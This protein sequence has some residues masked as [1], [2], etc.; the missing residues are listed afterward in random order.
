MQRQQGIPNLAKVLK[1][2][3]LHGALIANVESGSSVERAGLKTGDVATAI[4]GWPVLIFSQ[5]P[6][7]PG[8]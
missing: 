8:W 4:D 3:E 2:G 7:L 6:V 5:S 1:L